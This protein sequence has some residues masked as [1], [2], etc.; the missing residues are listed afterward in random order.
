MNKPNLSFQR[1]KQKT[2]KQKHP[3]TIFISEQTVSKQF[4]NYSPAQHNT[5]KESRNIEVFVDAD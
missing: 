5:T 3:F 4:G 2:K 1:V